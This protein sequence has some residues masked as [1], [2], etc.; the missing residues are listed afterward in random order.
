MHVRARRAACAAAAARRLAVARAVERQARKATHAVADAHA[1]GARALA[2]GHAR[3]IEA[4]ARGAALFVDGV[5][6]H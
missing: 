2:L 4:G 1:L 3:A 6:V 5:H